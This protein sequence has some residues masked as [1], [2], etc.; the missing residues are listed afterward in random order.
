MNQK[1]FVNIILIVIVVAIVAFGGYFVLSKKLATPPII[2]PQTPSSTDKDPSS[3]FKGWPPED[4]YECNSDL[5]C[6]SLY[7]PNMGNLAVHKNALKYLDE[8]KGKFCD[9]V[10]SDEKVLCFMTPGFE[11]YPYYKKCVISQKN[12]N[13]IQD[14]KDN[15]PKPGLPPDAKQP[16]SDD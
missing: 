16:F 13:V 12:D 1:G 15:L 7:C 5:D 14:Y 2:Q 10:I 9:P 6:V 11:D 3:P 8:F 4:N